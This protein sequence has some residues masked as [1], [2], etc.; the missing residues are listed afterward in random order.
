VARRFYRTNN[1]GKGL[2]T[3][4]DTTF[5][6]NF[7]LR[8]NVDELVYDAYRPA[9]LGATAPSASDS[10]AFPAPTARFSA[11]YA[12][13]LF[14]DGGLN[15]PLTLFY[16]SS[17][18]PDQFAAASFITLSGANGGITGLFAYYNVLVVFRENGVDVVKGSFN[19]GFSVTTVTSQVSC[20]SPNTVDTV[21]DVGIVFLAADGIYA[22][23]GGFEGGSVFRV[24]KLS[25][26]IDATISRA[27]QDCL[28][29]AVG[30]YSPYWSEYHCYFP[31][32]G[33]DR[34]S[35]GLVYHV[36]KKGW[37]LREDFPVGALDR[38][39]T[40]ELVFGH[41]TGA[42]TTSGLPCGLFIISGR[43]NMGGT[44]I[45]S[46]YV[47]SAAPTSRWRSPWLDLG[48]PQAKKKCQ[49]V[50]LW[51]LTTGNVS[52]TLTHYKD[53]ERTGI[54]ETS[55]YA[56]PPDQD[57][58]PV[59]DSAIL[60]STVWEK[61]RLVPIRI[62]V[63]NQSCSWFSFAFETSDDLVF[64]GWEVEYAANGTRV[65]AGQRVS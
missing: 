15:D 35:L 13:C 57:A 58:L 8:N 26:S 4:G 49:Y 24:V 30:R 32:D 34:P 3:Q 47:L 61:E 5:Y 38:M 23:N 37:S 50:T 52:I 11:V 12:D 51:M 36:D 48:D 53:F 54:T 55:Y 60:D 42:E 7:D 27:T 63:A 41:N 45:A 20:K 16:S 44:V 18:R 14:L 19:S 39:P 31:A 9:S 6:F 40:E 59:Y 17:G 65:V 2:P 28:A 21:P 46:E 1:Y 29:R 43:R 56:Q 10:V 64:A 22:I 62:S 33:Q 25:D